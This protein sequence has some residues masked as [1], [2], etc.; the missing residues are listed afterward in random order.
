MPHL[1][2]DGLLGGGGGDVLSD[3]LPEMVANYSYFLT[4]GLVCGAVAFA[5]RLPERDL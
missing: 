5:R 4:I 3:Y 1:L 2:A